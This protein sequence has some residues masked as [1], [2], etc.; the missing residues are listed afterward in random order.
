VPP[1]SWVWCTAWPA[2][3]TGDE[4]ISLLSASV[5]FEP[6][7]LEPPKAAAILPSGASVTK[8]HQSLQRMR[9]DRARLLTIALGGLVLLLLIAVVLVVARG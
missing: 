3:K 6:P 5:G 8:R 4:A 7:V 1:D 9:R 2:W